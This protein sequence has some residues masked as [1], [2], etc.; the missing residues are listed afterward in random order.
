M[1]NN[2]IVR[3]QN[4]RTTESKQRSRR[5]IFKAKNREYSRRTDCWNCGLGG[6]RKERC[7]MPH[8]LRCSY[9]QKRNVRSDECACRQPRKANQR[10][11]FHQVAPR[12]LP[13]K[14]ETAIFVSIYGKKVKALINPSVQETIICQ[15]VAAL[16]KIKTGN[17]IRKLIRREPGKLTLVSCI[18]MRL[19]TKV[20]KE[21]QIDGIINGKLK[22]KIIII[23]MEAISAMG[24][25]FIIGGQE[26]KIRVVKGSPIFKQEAREGPRKNT[27][28]PTTRQEEE[29]YDDEIS[30]LDEDE[31]R[32]IR[33]YK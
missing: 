29:D 7:P 1:V 27:S 16:V 8:R 17:T 26:A 24:F 22:G 31:A 2:K 10:K 21:V 32:M 33:E 19:K 4:S 23:G 13:T 25:T 9:C 20:S 6:H 15:E 11:K 12:S 14:M 3:F 18:Q 30:F 5:I 28:K